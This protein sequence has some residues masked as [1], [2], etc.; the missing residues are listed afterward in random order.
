VVAA[1][2]NEGSFPFVTDDTVGESDTA[3]PNNNEIRRSFQP[4]SYACSI[5]YAAWSL[6]RLKASTPT[7]VE[8]IEKLPDAL[9]GA[10]SLIRGDSTPITVVV[11]F[12]GIRLPEDVEISGAWGRIRPARMEEHPTLLKPMLERR[13]TTTTEAGE[14]I[15]ITDAGDVIYETQ[16]DMIMK[17]SREAG[18]M[19]WSTSTTDD[20]PRNDRPRPTSLC[21]GNQT[22]NTT[23]VDLDLAE[24]HYATRGSPFERS[25]PR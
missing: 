19:S 18:Q 4:L 9:S 3:V 13:T 20:P 11:S 2:R 7:L 23:C 1:V 6:A 17:I 8:V 5:I 21:L 10:R 16:L 15:E 12:T 25:N 22:R 14:R 24:G